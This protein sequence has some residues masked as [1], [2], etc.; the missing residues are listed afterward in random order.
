MLFIEGVPSSERRARLGNLNTAIGFVKFL[1]T[2][3]GG[4]PWS[5]IVEKNQSFTPCEISATLHE[6]VKMGDVI[7]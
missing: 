2:L 5:W 7:E 4:I 1:D 3:P 6:V